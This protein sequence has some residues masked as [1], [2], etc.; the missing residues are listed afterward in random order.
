MKRYRQHGPFINMHNTTAG[1][2][3]VLPASNARYLYA[4][5]RTRMNLLSLLNISAVQQNAYFNA[6][7]LG[8]APSVDASRLK[9]IRVDML[10]LSESVVPVTRDPT[11]YLY[12][13]NSR[14]AE[15][16]G[17]IWAAQPIVEIRP[18]TCT[19]I[20]HCNSRLDGNLTWFYIATGSGRWVCLGSTV[21]LEDHRSGDLLPV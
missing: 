5:R 16:K 4:K 15:P 18:H 21:V 12:R 13:D 6:L 8:H 7:Y 14:C 9:V 11:T 1:S 17:V 3:A 2:M 20:V 10:N 19:E